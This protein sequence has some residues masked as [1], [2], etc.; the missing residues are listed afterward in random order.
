MAA[1]GVLGA[2]VVPWAIGALGN[3]S[4]LRAGI[5]VLPVLMVAM[6]VVLLTASRYMQRNSSAPQQ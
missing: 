1:A 6:I 4:G 3:L 2:V 5:M